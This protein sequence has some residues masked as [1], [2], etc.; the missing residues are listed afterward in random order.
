MK[1]VHFGAGSIGRSFIGQI[2]ARS[3]WEV[4]FIDVD[5]KI[6]DEL[7]KRHRYSVI[8]KGKG[9]GTIE[10]ENVRGVLAS[11]QEEVVNEVAKADLLSTAVGQ[12]ALP[13]IMK[14]IALGILKGQALFPGRPL[15]IIICENMRNAARYFTEALQREISRCG[16]IPAHFSLKDQ[17]GFVETSIGKMVPIMSE[18]DRQK[19][20]L[21]V[22]A[23]A[24]NTLIV[25]KLAFKGNIPEVPQLDPKH[26]MK[27]Y[28][29]RKLY[30]H[31]LGHAVLGYTS[32][33]FNSDYSYVWEAAFDKRLSG[34]TELAMWE[35]GKALMAEYPDE[36][37]NR[38]IGNH[39]NDLIERF[40]NRALGDTIYRA[41]RDLYRKLG[42]DDRLIG[43]VQLC[44]KHDV[45]PKN[46]SLG[47]ASALFFKA[48]DE[49]GNMF[50]KDL[51]FHKEE[52]PKG[53]DHILHS[54][55]ALEDEE[56]KALIKRHYSMIEEG[57]RDI[58]DYN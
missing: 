28:V 10:V 55:C 3:G 41:G 58:S 1:L 14:H 56:V 43:G 4:V 53:I 34:V 54:I 5:Q 11:D 17:I 44:V 45:F 15:D 40:K 26:N 12:M 49:N 37:D 21:L 52:V 23:E 30:I 47:V 20:P 16:N 39:I 6:I 50:E 33:V 2:F 25:D 7:N 13:H 51:K 24:Y 57:K 32:Y 46:I 38:N 36:F 19:D 9:E 42:P 27:A 29:D 18:R 22:Y 31:N 48:Q 8:V 35:A